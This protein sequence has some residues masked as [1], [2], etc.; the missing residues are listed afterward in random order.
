MSSCRKPEIHT[1]LPKITKVNLLFLTKVVKNTM[2]IS[3]Y[4]NNYSIYFKK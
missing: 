4:F 2:F 1:D 3:S